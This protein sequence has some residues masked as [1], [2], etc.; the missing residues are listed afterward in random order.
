[1]YDAGCRGI[2]YGIESGTQ[3]VLDSKKKNI[4]PDQVRKAIKWTKE[5][6]I[7]TTGY[8][9]IGVPGESKTTIR[10]TMSFAREL[11]LDYYGF[12][13]T[14]PL[15]GTE[16]YDYALEAGLIQRNGTSPQDWSLH[17]NANLTD[18][19]SDAE[20]AAFE[21]KAFKEFFL[22]K[23]F[24]KY[25]FF[26]PDFLKEE[27]GVLLSLRNKEQARALANKAKNVVTSYWHKGKE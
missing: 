4:A 6:G 17:V 21:N 26:N 24:G 2:A 10:E 13:L 3:Q 14:T 18:D 5:A 23:R 7:N 11:E 8:F 15:I 22:K 19:C 27:L 12:S 9:M 20:L 16:L 1:M 25:Y